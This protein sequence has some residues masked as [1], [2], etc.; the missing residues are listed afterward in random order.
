MGAIKFV[1][2]KKVLLEICHSKSFRSIEVSS[3]HVYEGFSIL[4]TCKTLEGARARA[5]AGKKNTKQNP[6]L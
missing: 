2:R 5:G 4:K 1:L 6:R 3:V